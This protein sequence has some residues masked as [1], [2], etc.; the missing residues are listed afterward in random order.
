TEGFT[1]FGLHA[2]PY[3]SEQ[4]G[5]D[6]GFDSWRRSVDRAIPGQFLDHVSTTWTTDGRHFAYVHFIGPHSPVRP[7]AA[8]AARHGVDTAIVDPVKGMNIGEAKR[9]REGRKRNAYRAAYHAVLED[10]DARVGAVVAALGEHRGET[11][12]VLT[13][14]HGELLGEHGR[15]GHGR[16]VW[17][18]LSHVPLIV[19]HPALP[20]GTE[21]LPPA[22]GNVAVADLVTTGLGVAHRWPAGL[23]QPLPLVTQREGRLAISPDGRIKAMWDPDVSTDVQVFDLS[24]DPGETRP[25]R[26]DA[27]QMASARQ[28]FEAATPQGRADGASVQLHPDTVRQLQSLGYVP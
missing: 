27:G 10:T 28:D 22:L 16:H 3:L 18:A 1:T 9:D 2:N 19:D 14:D 26:D 13:S 6:R 15:V 17:E 20:G 24:A 23:S 7:S 11:L 12:I 21:S 8:A 4:L 25:G 5:F